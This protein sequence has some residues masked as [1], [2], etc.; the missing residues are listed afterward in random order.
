M[1]REKSVG[2]DIEIESLIQR[3]PE[4]DRESLEHVIAQYRS[5]LYRTALRILG[6]AEDAEDALQE[7][8][9]SASKNIEHFQRRSK[10]S[11][12]L[13]R[14]VINAALMARRRKRRCSEASLDELLS[15]VAPASLISLRDRRPGPEEMCA[16][17][18]IGRLL[19]DHFVR[20]APSLRVALH[21]H[22]NYGLTV[23]ETS[24]ILGISTSAVKSRL[25]RA[26]RKLANGLEPSFVTSHSR[27]QFRSRTG[28]RGLS[29]G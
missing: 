13:T 11:T 21:L 17:N 12:W 19:T 16:S 3:T 10:I 29:A 4:E 24:L 6:N 27:L 22:N 25:L 15:G 9:F 26:R 28:V 7:G 2:T 1:N 14:I 23:G 8:L 20:L 5:R 18:E